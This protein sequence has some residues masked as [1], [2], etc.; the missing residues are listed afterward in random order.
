MGVGVI[1]FWVHGLIKELWVRT[2]N[3]QPRA[4]RGIIG[5]PKGPFYV[6]SYPLILNVPQI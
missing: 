2:S 6:D 5:D 4:S 3:L 1:G